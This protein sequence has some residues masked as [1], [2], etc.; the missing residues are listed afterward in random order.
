MICCRFI[1]L[2]KNKAKISVMHALYT[3]VHTSAVNHDWGCSDKKIVIDTHKLYRNCYYGQWPIFSSV[4]M[5]KWRVKNIQAGHIC[6]WK[7]KL[8][9]AHACTSVLFGDQ[10]TAFWWIAA[11]SKNTVHHIHAQWQPHWNN[12]SS[13]TSDQFWSLDQCRYLINWLILANI[14]MTADI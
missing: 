7:C 3:D 10:Q 8:C 9:L 11:F 4:N 14:N 6:C 13:F 12:Q 2:Y 1:P 5:I